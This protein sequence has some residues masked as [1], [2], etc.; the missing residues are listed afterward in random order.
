MGLDN[1]DQNYYDP[2]FK[3]DNHP[4]G[5]NSN[6]KQWQEY[7][8]LLKSGMFW[9]F[10]PEL[11]GNW[12]KDKE[13]WKQLNHIE[14]MTTKDRVENY[15]EVDGD[16]IQLALQGEF[17]VIAHGVNCFCTQK[18]GLAPQMV[19][20]FGTDMFD[21]EIEEYEDLH[22]DFDSQPYKIR[23][24]NKGDINKL[25]QIQYETKYLWFNH[26]SGK[27]VAMN[28]RIRGQEN[29]QKLIVVNAYTQYH[30][31]KNHSDGV[32]NPID[33]E[34]LTLCMRKINHTFKGKHIG[35]PG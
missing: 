22:K 20:V 9:E 3:G 29:T 16:L 30:Y 25:G 7:N 4:W 32:E 28:S 31:G 13:A 2:Y 11:T 26:P 19:K 15:K 12:E 18:S 35:L 8:K 27:T 24:T 17:D 14:L 34:A 1:L 6:Y 21:L 5:D 23:T 10:H 33:Y